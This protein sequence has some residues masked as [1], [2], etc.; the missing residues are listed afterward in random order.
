MAV[1]TQEV[2]TG[3][4]KKGSIIKNWSDKN[5]SRIK[6]IKHSIR[7]FRKSPLAML[8][9]VIIVMFLLVALFAPY[10]APF[11]AEERNWKEL[12]Q[13]PSEKHI[14]GTD[15]TGGDIFSRILYGS[16]TSLYIG[17]SVVSVAIILG[18]LVGS[19]SGYYGGKIDELMM[20]ITDIFLAFPSLVLAMVI[21]AFLGRSVENVMLAMTI[22]WWP[23]YARLVRG[24]ALSI[25]ERKYIEAARAIG[26]SDFR[27][28]T[29][30]LAPN[31]FSPIIVQATMDLGNV[32]LVAAGL[33]F[34][35]FGAKPGQAEWG[36]MISEG[37][38]YMLNQPWM[39]TFPGLAILIVCL[40]F[41]LFGDGLRDILDPR[42][43]R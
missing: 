6:E 19:I 39:A 4:K 8:G 18:T 15:D 32:I 37:A 38:A 26:A 27:I 21:C 9:F 22:V 31:S 34:I 40:G 35:G 11:G 43:R 33:S 5:E 42:Q 13:A 30:H 10:I 16:R 7:L 25:R 24:Q 1:E 28:I 2:I 17:F 14:F 3:Q 41:N 29:K 23:A 12:K 20:R 36:R